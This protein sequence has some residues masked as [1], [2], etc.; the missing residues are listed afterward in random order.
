MASDPEHSGDTAEDIDDEVEEVDPSDDPNA[1]AKS[2]LRQTDILA[3]MQ[4]RLR[5]EFLQV[6]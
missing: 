4:G 1:L 3:A 6:S 2:V 5:E